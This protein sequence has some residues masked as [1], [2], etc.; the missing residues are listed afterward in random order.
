MR[1]LNELIAKNKLQDQ[2]FLYAPRHIPR[3]TIVAKRELPPAETK[4]NGIPVTGKIPK[5]IPTCTKIWAR[6]AK[7]NPE[8]YA[9]EEGETECSIKTVILIKIKKLAMRISPAPIRPSSSAVEEKIK[10][11]FFSGKKA[12]CVWVPFPKPFP[13]TP[14]EPA[15]IVA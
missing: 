9:L 13:K 6:N 1:I 2:F 12:S 14:P 8:R 11:V 10:S 5:F 7:K 3:P 4:G 15:A